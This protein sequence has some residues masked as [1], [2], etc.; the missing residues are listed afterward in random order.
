MQPINQAPQ[1]DG[2]PERR[3]GEWHPD[4]VDTFGLQIDIRLNDKPNRI[5]HEGESLRTNERTQSESGNTFL[6]DV[7][8]FF[9]IG[10]DQRLLVQQ[11]SFI[12]AE[13][14]PKGPTRK[15][16]SVTRA[17]PAEAVRN[18]NPHSM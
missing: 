2:V 9:I 18:V 14:L 15:G 12:G 1:D 3:V 10:A 6:H 7:Q 11:Q 16:S 5:I 8:K 13:E 4:D 17:K